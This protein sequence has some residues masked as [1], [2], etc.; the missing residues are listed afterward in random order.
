MFI[1]KLSG[2]NN[3]IESMCMFAIMIALVAD[4][5][6]SI[7]IAYII[8]DIIVS[9]FFSLLSFVILPII[10]VT[11]IT[12]KFMCIPDIASRCDI[13]P[14]WKFSLICLSSSVLS[15]RIIALKY[16][17]VC[18]EKF[19]RNLFLSFVDVF[20]ISVFMFVFVLIFSMV[21][22]SRVPYIF[23]FFR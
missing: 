12:I 19:F 2:L 7:I 1:R 9:F 6:K 5:E 18:F 20:F 21:V 15:P 10:Y 23:S 22:G 16:S 14:S 4:G 17:A 13:P 3:R 11:M 8:N